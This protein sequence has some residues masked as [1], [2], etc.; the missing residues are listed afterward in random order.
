MLL[1]RH[2]KGG[3]GMLSKE[4]KMEIYTERIWRLALDL[5]AQSARLG[6]HGRGI[7][8]VAEETRRLSL[9]IYHLLD[10]GMEA[11]E[12]RANE[13]V[14][15][16]KALAFN[17]S[18]EMTYILNAFYAYGHIYNANKYIADPAEVVLDEI[19][20]V[21]ID[22]REVFGLRTENE[23]LPQPELAKESKVANA[24]LFLTQTTIGGK[25]FVENTAFINE[26]AGCH[27]FDANPEDGV[28]NLR[29][30]KIPVVNCYKK[31][32]LPGKPTAVLFVKTDWEKDEK[33]YA[34]LVDAL[35][36]SFGFYSPFAE[37][38]VPSRDTLFT[39]EYV[40]AAWDT[41]E[42]G[43][44]LFMDWNKLV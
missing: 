8:V 31:L 40:R 14:F 27:D 43:Q 34:V 42:G 37:G 29:G 39:D 36:A 44:M 15:Q 35:P 33:R 26:V 9:Q 4:R 30:L 13:I 23:D 12:S 2:I 19:I 38:Q 20:N 16:I 21:V 1:A 5:A 3:N 25:A 11:V 28:I 41:A 10:E 22:F 6:E 7:A 18:L 32:N 24:R 17:G